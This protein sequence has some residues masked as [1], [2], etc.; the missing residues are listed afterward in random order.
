MWLKHSGAWRAR[1]IQTKVAT[2]RISSGYVQC[3]V[4]FFLQYVWKSIDSSSYFMIHGYFFFIFLSLFH[5]I[6]YSIKLMN[7]MVFYCVFSH[8]PNVMTFPNS[9]W[10]CPNHRSKAYELLTT[11]GIPEVDAPVPRAR[12]KHRSTPSW[13]ELGTNRGWTDVWYVQT[14]T[15]MQQKWCPA[16]LQNKNPSGIL[17]SKPPSKLSKLHLRQQIL[18]QRC[19]RRPVP[20]RDAELQY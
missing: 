11:A 4:L 10:F 17:R 19:G 12:I 16:L 18:L 7:Y 15:R 3:L 20:G 13:V 9:I 14:L 1:G 5:S 8:A 6:I 2:R